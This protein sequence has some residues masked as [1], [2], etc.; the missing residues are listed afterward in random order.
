MPIK[1][2]LPLSQTLKNLV[3]D[4]NFKK[5]LLKVS[6]FLISITFVEAILEI[7]G[8]AKFMKDFETKKRT[9]DFKT[10]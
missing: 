6:N 5:F 3:D 7:D 1:I 8:Y 4:T 9:M 2:P 10:V